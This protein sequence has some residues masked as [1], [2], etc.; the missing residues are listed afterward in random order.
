MIETVTPSGTIVVDKH[1]DV[2]HEAAIVRK[3]LLGKARVGSIEAGQDLRNRG[4]LDRHGRLTRCQW[5]EDGGN[6][7]GNAHDRNLGRRYRTGPILATGRLVAPIGHSSG[8]A[9]PPTPV[10]PTMEE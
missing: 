5:T 8:S 9:L 10:S 3:K 4:A 1:V 6:S 7:D 2:A